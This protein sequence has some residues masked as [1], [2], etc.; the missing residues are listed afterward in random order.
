[1][2]DDL[3]SG[4]ENL[5]KRYFRSDDRVF[6]QGDG[7]YYSLREGDHGPFQTEQSARTDLRRFINEQNDLNALKSGK[8][9]SRAGPG[10]PLSVDFGNDRKRPVKSAE[11][12]VWKGLPDVD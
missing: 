7:W 8:E 10:T 5:K 12:D 6:R 9:A 11:R 1:M 4:D 3:R 2:V